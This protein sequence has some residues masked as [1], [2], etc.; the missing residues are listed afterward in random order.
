ME[1]QAEDA[2][3]YGADDTTTL[4]IDAITKPASVAT[5]P[6]KQQ[7]SVSRGP[8][9]RTTQNHPERVTSCQGGRALRE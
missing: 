7:F 3:A 2:I 1:P 9:A 8:P 4:T 5:T 6:E